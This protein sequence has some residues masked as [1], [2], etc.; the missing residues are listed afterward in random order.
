MKIQE[1]KNPRMVTFSSLQC[2]DVF[3]HGGNIA[4]KIHKY[5]G[6]YGTLQAIVLDNGK[7][8]R[9]LFKDGDIMVESL[10]DATLVIN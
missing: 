3:R 10:T 7:H 8:Y 5:D 6:E 9:D 2:G 4:I 1:N